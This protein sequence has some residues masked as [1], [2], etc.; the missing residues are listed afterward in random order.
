MVKIDPQLCIANFAKSSHSLNPVI[1]AETPSPSV[2]SLWHS[3]SA[4]PDFRLSTYPEAF[5]EHFAMGYG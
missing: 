2:L 3:S 5:F 1:R 4:L